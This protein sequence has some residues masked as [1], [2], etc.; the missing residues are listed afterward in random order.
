[1]WT[2]ISLIWNLIRRVSSKPD[3]ALFPAERSPAPPLPSAQFPPRSRRAA[4]PAPSGPTGQA[5][6]SPRAAPARL[7][8]RLSRVAE[9]PGLSVVPARARSVSCAPRGG[10]CGGPSPLRGRAP[11]SSQLSHSPGTGAPGPHGPR[12]VRQGPGNVFSSSKP[13][14]QFDLPLDLRERPNATLETSL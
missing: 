12:L 2:Q 5:A 4:F 11:E 7:F 13:S 1:M 10:L 8:P 14:R 9:L 3:G 6:A